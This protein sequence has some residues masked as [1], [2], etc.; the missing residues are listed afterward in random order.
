MEPDTSSRGEGP[1]EDPS[2]AGDPA[3]GDG[4]GPDA[5]RAGEPDGDDFADPG[6]AGPGGV[7][8]A[9]EAVRLGDGSRPDGAGSGAAAPCRP[10]DAARAALRAATDNSVER[11]EA[12]SADDAPE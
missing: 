3:H 10:A 4:A 5:G 7:A 6:D 2:T 11:P 1:G 8:G 12:Q 9:E